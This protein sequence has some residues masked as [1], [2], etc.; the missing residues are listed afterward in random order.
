MYPFRGLEHR[1]Y[2]VLHCVKRSKTY[3]KKKHVLI[4][5]CVCT[6][7]RVYLTDV[8]KGTEHFFIF[9]NVQ[10][11]DFRP[12]RRTVEVKGLVPEGF[13]SMAFGPT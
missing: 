10:C 1:G 5:I 3:V 7:V 2:Y 11:L 9:E 8:L 12:L 6:H 4:H 13:S